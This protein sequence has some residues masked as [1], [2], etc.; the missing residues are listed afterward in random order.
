MN[1]FI[2]IVLTVS[3]CKLI[4]LWILNLKI[5]ENICFKIAKN[6]KKAMRILAFILLTDGF[7]GILCFKIMLHGC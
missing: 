2:A 4:A 1:I 6:P 3:I 7:I 5:L